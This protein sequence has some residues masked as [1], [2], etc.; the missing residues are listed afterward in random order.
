MVGKCP[1]RRLQCHQE[2]W[3]FPREWEILKK[4]NNSLPDLHLYIYNIA[5]GAVMTVRVKLICSYRDL[6]QNQA[7]VA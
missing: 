2:V 4:L 5:S 7:G 3:M 6:S 1:P